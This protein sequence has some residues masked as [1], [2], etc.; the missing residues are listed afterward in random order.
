MTLGELKHSLNFSGWVMSDWD[1]THSTSLAQGLDQE[2]PGDSFMGPDKVVAQLQ[3][4]VITQAD[5]DQAVSRMLRPMFSVGL[6]DAPAGSYDVSK[7]AVNAS[8]AESIAVAK[9]LVISSAVLLKN[10]GTLPL[11]KPSAAY[12]GRAGIAVFGLAKSPIYGGSGSGSVVPSAPVSPWDAITV[13]GGPAHARGF[14]SF[15]DHTADSVSE[16]AKA[17]AAADI[18]L[19][20]VATSSGEGAD[21][22]TLG[23]GNSGNRN[24]KSNGDQDELVR[25]VCTASAR[26]IVVVCTPGAVLLPWAHSKSVSAVLTVFMPGQQF[27]SAIAE[28]LFGDANPSGKL[29]LTFPNKDNEMQFSPLQWPG[30]KI[31]PTGSSLYK[32]ESMT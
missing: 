13:E 15:L 14:T 30:T 11:L 10:D 6:F 5:I 27:G 16:A 24:S 21:R 19:V 23:L 32:F 17:A 9:Q 12:S 20:F 22:Q 31:P 7:H 26:C 18:S 3:K 8:T 1:A 2:M 25:A 28:L 4:G 29:P